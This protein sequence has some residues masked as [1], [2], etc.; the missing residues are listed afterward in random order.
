M[1]ATCIP[2]TQDHVSDLI[3]INYL[4]SFY[5][6]LSSEMTRLMAPC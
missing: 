4:N 2:G 1:H 3:G 6:E 5:D